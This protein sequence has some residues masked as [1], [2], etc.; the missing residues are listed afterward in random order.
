MPILSEPRDVRR[1]GRLAI[2]TIAW[3]SI[4]CVLLFG[5]IWLSSK[6]SRAFVARAELAALIAVEVI[7]GTIAVLSL[8]GA[9][10]L[11]A[12]WLRIRRTGKIRPVVPRAPLLCGSLVLGVML[13][14]AASAAWRWRQSGQT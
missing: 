8:L 2:L 7:Y 5:A 14:E 12:L 11:L 10:V 1:I 4:V 9:L 13:A 3:A 6:A